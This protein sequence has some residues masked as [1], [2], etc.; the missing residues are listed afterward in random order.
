MKKIVVSLALALGLGMTQ[1][2][3]KE[4][5]LE[6]IR[7]TADSEKKKFTFISPG[8]GRYHFM[9]NEAFP[10]ENIVIFK[11]LPKTDSAVLVIKTDDKVL[12]EITVK[13]TDHIRLN[14]TKY[15]S[16]PSLIWLLTVTE[17]EEVMK[18]VIDLKKY[19]PPYFMF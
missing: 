4:P 1:A 12:D 16:Y 14:L 11:W 13:K 2:G 7:S 9:I 15:S 18:G 6:S 3:D 8:E 19:F 10:E 5:E 17:S